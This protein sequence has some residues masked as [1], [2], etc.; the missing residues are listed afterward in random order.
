[1]TPAE[2]H[3]PRQQQRLLDT[4]QK[5]LVLPAIDLPTAMN[6][7]AQLVHEALNADKVDAFL[8]DSSKNSLRA[9]GTSDTPMGRQ[10]R[11]QGLDVLPLANGGQVARVYQS[12]QPYLHGDMEQEQDEVPGLVHVLGI[13]S[14]ILVPLDVS[15]DRRGVLSAQSTARD[16]FT[17]ED[18][19]FLQA[20]A[21]WVGALAHRAELVDA[22]TLAAREHGRR[23]SAEELVLVLAHDLRNHLSPLANRIELMRLRAEREHRTADLHD[24]EGARLAM[25]RLARLISD[26]LDVERIEQGIFSLQLQPVDLMALLHETARLLSCPEVGVEV[27]G[28]PTLVVTGDADRLRQALENLIGNAI[29]HTPPGKGVAVRAQLDAPL[30]APPF[31]LIDIV[32][33]GPGILP[34]ILPHLFERFAR[35]GGAQG[36]GLGLYLAQRIAVA[37]GGT[38]M[39]SS[40]IGEGASFR[41]RLPAAAACPVPCR[42]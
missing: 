24:V 7:A 18:L 8:F 15:G 23:E 5:L 30:E 17:K 21:C 12:G 32:D 4:L 31:A 42:S 6:Q 2:N 38:L 37:H 1:M 26:L 29:K 22:S 33:Q 14:Q 25:K 9:M 35:A 10:Q 16:F 36:L 11:A 19:R 41:L 34:E 27:S 39:V 13:H 28:P 40:T 20:V 3:S